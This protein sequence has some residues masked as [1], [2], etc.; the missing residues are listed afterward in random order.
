MDFNREF[1]FNKDNDLAVVGG[2]D[3]VK[4]SIINIVTTNHGEKPFD[5]TYGA[6][7]E[8]QLHDDATLGLIKSIENSVE[9]SISAREP[10]VSNVSAFATFNIGSEILTINIKFTYD[11]AEHSLS[12]EENK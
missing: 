3:A 7:L 1:D 6:D 8:S 2:V 5:Y 12:V 10:R 9:E 4:Q 11:G